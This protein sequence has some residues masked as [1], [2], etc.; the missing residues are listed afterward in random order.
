MGTGV[1]VK[2]YQNIVEKGQENNNIGNVTLKAKE[3]A[4]E[5]CLR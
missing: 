1:I 3:M 4:R 2:T 5:T